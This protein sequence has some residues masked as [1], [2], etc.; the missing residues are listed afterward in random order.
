MISETQMKDLVFQFR[1]KIRDTVNKHRREHAVIPEPEDY[2]QAWEQA[3]TEEA[4]MV[5]EVRRPGRPPKGGPKAEPK[6]GPKKGG[7]GT[8]KSSRPGG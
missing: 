8:S 4:P 6:G 7:K 1:K 2:I 5:R 3:L